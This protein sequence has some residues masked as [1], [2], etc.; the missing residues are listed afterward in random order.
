MTRAEPV[1]AG[2]ILEVERHQRGAAALGADRVVKFLEPA[3]GARHRDHMG[4]GLRPGA[5]AAA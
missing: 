1:D 2:E 3:G 5:S 4:A